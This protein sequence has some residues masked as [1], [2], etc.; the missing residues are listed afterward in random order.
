[1]SNMPSNPE[2]LRLKYKVLSNCW[3]MGQL[4]QP[5]WHLF[6]KFGCEQ[7]GVCPVP[8]STGWEQDAQLLSSHGGCL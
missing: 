2:E 5:G 6:F 3:L 4:G 7:T 8:V 1:M